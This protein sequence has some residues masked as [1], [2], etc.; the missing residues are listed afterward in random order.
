MNKNIRT[1]ENQDLF[2]DRISFKNALQKGQGRAFLFVHKFGLESVFDLFMESCI[3]N[4][5]YD[6]QC[7][8]SRSEW[9][10]SM[11]N[12]TPYFQEFHD[13]ILL[14][15]EKGKNTW[16]LYQ[17]CE[18]VRLL[19]SQGDSLAEERLKMFVMKM[20]N[21]NTNQDWFS[22][23][24]WVEYKGI[25]GILEL[26]R[27]Y[28]EYL[29]SNQDNDVNDELLYCASNPDFKN[30]LFEYSLKEPAIKTYWNYLEQ[31]GRLEYQPR[32]ID[33]ELEKA[34]TH[35][36]VRNRY[37]LKGIMKDAKMKRKR[38][39][40]DRFQIFGRHALPEELE[41][42]YR[43]ILCEE[44]DEVRIR[45]LWIFRNAILPKLDDKFFSWADSE[46]ESLREI[47]IRAISQISNEKVHNLA[48]EK[49][50]KG[51]LT[52]ADNKAI[53]LFLNNYEINDGKLIS[54]ALNNLKNLDITDVHSLGFSIVTLSK[55]HNDPGLSNA[56]KWVYEE[57]PCTNCRSNAV[58]HLDQY[59][60]LNKTLIQ[61]CKV[62]ADWSIRE[63]VAN[64]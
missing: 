63:F 4:Q 56:L 57:T 13:Q 51:Q 25:D 12:E 40:P 35:E 1:N 60:Q 29:Q 34:K 10:F 59:H 32:I 20:A 3:H 48:K 38:V 33:L 19:V 43:Q 16:D 53:D 7:E 5:S 39:F 46:N 41:F 64:M 9:L 47:T 6:P 54:K 58:V 2:L 62:D 45:L 61:E 18:L 22:S 27:I 24:I 17:L 50:R 42:I 14:A 49:T 36:K 37:S 11:I 44:D 15:I 26:A 23:R 55:K 21:K 28:G 31:L 8:S 30:V 52:G